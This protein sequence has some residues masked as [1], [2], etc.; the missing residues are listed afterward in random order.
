MLHQVDFNQIIKRNVIKAFAQIHA[1]EVCHGDVRVENILVRP[2]NSVV[3]IDFETSLTQAPTD[4]LRTE[5]KEVKR[6][7]ASL[8]RS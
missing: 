8:E 3:I 4:R 1:R 7:L 2:D 5:A 6:L